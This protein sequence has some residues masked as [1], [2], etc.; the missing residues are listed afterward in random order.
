MHNNAHIF[1]ESLFECTLSFKMYLL[2]R[3][4]ENKFDKK[5]LFFVGDDSVDSIRLS[6]MKN[7]TI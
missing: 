7:V 6:F 5:N 3:R 2:Y 1:L 4:L